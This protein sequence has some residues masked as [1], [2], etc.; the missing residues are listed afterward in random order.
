MLSV[1]QSQHKSV[2]I[3]L[4]NFNGYE[5][6]LECLSSICNSD[7]PL[8]HLIVI[9]NGSTDG[10]LKKIYD[11]SHNNPSVDGVINHDSSSAISC[12]SDCIQSTNRTTVPKLILI[13]N[14]Q[15]VGFAAGCNQGMKI[16]IDAGF[17]YIWL[18][19]ND[20]V[21]ERDSL[22]VLVGY[23]EEVPE[24][25]LASPQIRLFDEPKTIWN[26]GGLLKWYG[27]RKYFFVH[28]PV[29]E[30]P[31]VETLDITFVTGCAPLMRRTLI[32]DM[33]MFTEKFFF[34]EEDFDFSLRMKN[35]KRKMVCCLNSVIYHKVGSSIDGITKEQNLGKTYIHYLNRFINLR[36][37]WPRPIWSCWR[38]V[39][40]V[41]IYLLLGRQNKH[42]SRVRCSFIQKLF[43]DSSHMDTVD[44]E[45]FHKIISSQR[46]YFTS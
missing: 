23:L 3:V 14:T 46:D 22:S 20:T 1:S 4:L 12:L 21:I 33:G 8:V 42:N 2:A 30:L 32:E 28:R 26:C 5:D 27:V 11:W 34:G 9:D 29:S 16:A 35:T 6:T 41:Y 25:H 36:E 37:H 15:N 44:K 7:Y 39:Y 13:E 18:L 31:Q 17:D 10:S 40:V 45:L 43:K 19:N 38:V 24:C